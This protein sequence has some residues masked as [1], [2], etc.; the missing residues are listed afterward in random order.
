MQ[1]R[2]RK[3]KLIALSLNTIMTSWLTAAA[4]AIMYSENITASARS[5]RLGAH[6]GCRNAQ[7]VKQSRAKVCDAKSNKSIRWRILGH[8]DLDHCFLIDTTWYGVV[9]KQYGNSMK[10]GLYAWFHTALAH[11]IRWYE[12]EVCTDNLIVRSALLNVKTCKFMDVNAFS[13]NNPCFSRD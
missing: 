12:R 13:P 1:Q 8:V 11:V 6:C 3:L 5:L 4:G 2:R 10:N 7:V 9:L